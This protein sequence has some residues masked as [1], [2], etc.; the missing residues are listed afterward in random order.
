MSDPSD[1]IACLINALEG[2]CHVECEMGEDRMA[3]VYLAEDFCHEWKGA[4]KV[5]KPELAALGITP[6]QELSRR[7]PRGMMLVWIRSLVSVCPS[8]LLAQPAKLG[9]SLLIV[10]LG[11]RTCGL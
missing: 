6:V 8:Q 5:L 1:A 11:V 7:G 2:C 9:A 3:T 10:R 4:L